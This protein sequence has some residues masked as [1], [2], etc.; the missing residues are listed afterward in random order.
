MIIFCSN[1]ITK[2]WFWSLLLYVYFETR[3]H[4]L[5]SDGLRLMCNL[6]WSGT[7]G[8]FPV[9]SPQIFRLRHYPS[10]TVFSHNHFV[11]YN[12]HGRRLVSELL[13]L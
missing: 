13:L 12:H 1:L 10:V 8:H 5:A 2:E 7:H 11:E 3:S 6:G 4:F 9:S